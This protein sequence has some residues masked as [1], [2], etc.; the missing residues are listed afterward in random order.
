MISRNW[1]WND[2]ACLFICICSGGVFLLG[3]LHR[4]YVDPLGLYVG[5]QEEYVLSHLST[6]GQATWY[7]S[8]V[9]TVF[10]IGIWL[11]WN[12]K[13]RYMRIFSALYL[14]LTFATIVTQNSDSAF[15]AL[16]TV[17]LVLLWKSAESRDKWNRFQQIVLLLTASFTGTGML[18]RI[19]AYRAVKPGK[20]SVFLTQ[21]RWTTFF[22]LLVAVYHFGWSGRTDK[23]DREI[24]IKVRKRFFFLLGVALIG[25]FVFIYLNST[26][27]LSEWTKKPGIYNELLYFDAR[28]GNGRGFIWA[29]SLQMFDRFSILQKIFGVGP[30]CYG[31]FAYQIPE[32]ADRLNAV[33]GSRSVLCAHNEP[34]NML[35]CYGCAGMAA[36]YSCFVSAIK[37]YYCRSDDRPYVFAVVLCLVSYLTHNFFCYQQV[38]CTPIIFVFMGM[39]ESVL[40]AE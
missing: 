33:W 20:L 34:L 28:W 10:P 11:F 21:S 31:V 35:I 16:G 36:Y 14:A 4:F 7:S 38:V 2:Y 23:W 32:F 22:L 1:R 37:Q 27:I 9:C 13:S 15:A 17:L 39:A 5:L 25:F 6:I 19:F 18:Q 29:I 8:F 30:D 24:T 3:F 12:N 40:R 26:G